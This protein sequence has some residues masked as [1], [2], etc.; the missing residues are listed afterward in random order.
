MIR[1]LFLI[2]Y[3]PI[4]Q[5]WLERME[6]F[7]AHATLQRIHREIS[8]NLSRPIWNFFERCRSR[9]QSQKVS[10]LLQVGCRCSRTLTSGLFLFKPNI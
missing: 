6:H 8:E 3:T 10:A 5:N 1:H 2:S 4:T 7:S 9:T